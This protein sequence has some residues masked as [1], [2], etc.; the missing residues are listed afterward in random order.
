MTRDSIFVIEPGKAARP[1]AAA[2]FLSEAELQAL[3]ADNPAVLGGE[4]LGVE[5]LRFLLVTREA[6][7]PDAEDAG[8]RWALDHIF[9]DQHATPTLVEVKRAADTRIRREVVGQMLDYAANT[10][11]YWPLD[12]LRR[13]T[14]RR[15]GEQ[16]AAEAVCELVGNGSAQHADDVVDNFWQRVGQRLRAGEVRL[17]FVADEIPPEL[18]RVIEFLNEQMPR[19]HVVGL[20]LAQYGDGNLRVLVPKAVGVT[21]AARAD[22]SQ[23]GATGPRATEAT[24]LAECGEPAASF[25]ADVLAEAARHEV[26]VYWGV[27][28]FSLHFMPPKHSRKTV[29]LHGYPP[30]SRKGGTDPILWVVLNDAEFP[31]VTER[32]ELRRHVLACG[33]FVASGKYTL[34]L[35]L[36][37]GTLAS[38]RKA[39]E[40]VWELE[41]R[42]RTQTATSIRSDRS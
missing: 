32:E 8:N 20:E 2:R 34:S 16:G 4:R 5:P 3:L 7:V 29:L 25:F 42:L 39:A 14:E 17:V 35:D 36:N 38:A 11:R 26:F 31:D 6:G 1:V 21:E 28:G 30:G 15:Y 41:G 40:I 23:A 13:L 22:K 9:V 12:Q 37:P 19:V 33:G 24:F 18:R 27:R 10:Q